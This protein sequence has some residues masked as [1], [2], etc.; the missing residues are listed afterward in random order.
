MKRIASFL[1]AL[2]LLFS[3]AAYSQNTK[4]P[5]RVIE[6]VKVEGF[7]AEG[8]VA[9]FV[10]GDAIRVRQGKLS[11]FVARNFIADGDLVEVRDDS[12]AELLLNPGTYLRL[13]PRTRIAFLDLSADNVKLRLIKGSAILE[14]VVS[15]YEFTVSSQSSVRGRFNS[16][17]Q[18]ITLMAPDGEFVTTKG[19]IYRCDIDEDGRS[20]LKVVKGVAAIAGNVVSEGM[21]APLGDRVPTIAAFD[22][23]QED[24]FDSWSHRRATALIDL[25]KTLRSTAWYQQLKK[26]SQTYV[27]ITYDESSERLKER[28]LVSAIGGYVGYAEKGA[29]YQSENSGWQPLGKDVELKYGDAVKTGPDARVEIRVYP[30]CYLTLSTNTEI[31]YGSRK[32][33]GASIEVLRGAAILASTVPRKDGLLTSLVAART[34]IEIPGKGLYRLNV[35]PARESELLVYEGKATIA[36]RNVDEDHRVVFLVNEVEVGPI[37]RRDL[38]AFELWSRKRSSVLFETPDRYKHTGVSAPN[39]HRAR[40]FGLWCLVPDSEVYTFVPTQIGLKS[41][42]GGNYSIGFQGRVN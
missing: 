6:V 30:S 21:T 28:M 37:R 24:S 11:R 34:E 40:N 25:N 2:S 9:N 38:D 32:D 1:W 35:V 39:A 15:E 5:K 4:P 22:R 31:I 13:A 19:G 20:R 36:G 14:T 18:G 12:Y 16:S 23:K 33:G 29:L 41:P 10:Q 7:R 27:D 8:G 42:Y 17:Y 26:N 3:A